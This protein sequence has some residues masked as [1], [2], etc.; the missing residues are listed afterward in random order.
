MR[1]R[2]PARLIWT[3]IAAGG[4]LVCLLL[5]WRFA[6]ALGD[7]WNDARLAPTFGLRHGVPLWF[8]YGQGPVLDAIYGPI[9]PL[10]WLPA[11]LAD[12]PARA[13]GIAALLSLV[14]LLA[15]VLCLLRM[16]TR[17]HVALLASTLL[18]A[19][20][21]QLSTP[22][23][24]VIGVHTDV[25]ALGYATAALACAW[26]GRRRRSAGWRWAGAA[27][28]IASAGSKQV[29]APM[30]VAYPAWIAVTS[31]WRV[32]R[33]MLVAIGG[34]GLAALAAVVA[35]FDEAAMID[36]TILGPARHPWIDSTPAALWIV[37]VELIRRST[38]FLA[39]LALAALLVRRR[40]PTWA[41]ALRGERLFPLAM[42]VA[43]I[44]TSLV[45]GAKVG[46]AANA[47]SF[48]IWFVWLALLAAVASAGRRRPRVRETLTAGAAFVGCAL[49]L[50]L[51][52]DLASLPQALR[53]TPATS[54]AFAAARERPETI[55]F[56]HRPVVG[57][58][59]DRR[60]YY[61]DPGLQFRGY[62]GRPIDDR[63]VRAY[64][65]RALERVAADRQVMPYA[66]TYLPRYRRQILDPSLP[67]WIVMTETDLLVEGERPAPPADR[68]DLPAAVP[69]VVLAGSDR[70][71][72]LTRAEVTVPDRSRRPVVRL[73][74]DLR[75]EMP[76]EAVEVEVLLRDREGR[77]VVTLVARL[78]AHRAGRVTAEWP[79]Y[80][81][82]LR[83]AAD[84]LVL[85][86]EGRPA[87]GARWRLEAE[88]VRRL[89]RQPSL[90]R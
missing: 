90:V 32:A 67:G 60:A 6:L 75:A 23:M 76:H 56:P 2:V 66:L 19:L 47:L 42:A 59:A 64:L 71:V 65:P 1:P 78:P 9:G 86:R 70:P 55:Y 10:T 52:P 62:E 26:T 63:F 3:V 29:M 11:T 12:T 81:D 73:Q 38:P 89:V 40:H 16:E 53:E 49:A 37:V 80:A 50:R 21:L 83:S 31:G 22:A 30:L 36:A 14:L 77:Q 68:G 51:A 5:V 58:M 33:R 35:A 46:G 8:P 69:A 54:V 44:P 20:A 79:T 84:A 25:P 45:G 87:E 18:L 34:V 61:L 41:R 72:M 82:L 88:D 39:L 48:T 28:L 57:M 74:A 17:R 4:T 43:L 7:E 24:P 13:I 15:P 85:V 27:F